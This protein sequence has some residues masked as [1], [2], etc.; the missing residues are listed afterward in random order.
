M[1]HFHQQGQGRPLVL[2]HGIGMSHK[3]WSPVFDLLAAQRKVIAFDVAGFGNSPILS[4]GI[5]PTTAN[6]A[7]QLGEELKRLGVTEPVDIVGNSM[8]GWMALEAARLGLA[9]SV[10]A[11]SP[12]GLWQQAPARAKYIFFGLR[13]LAGNFPQLTKKSLEFKI[14]RELFM[15]VPLSIGGRHIP[16]NIAFDLTMDFVNAQGF[17]ETFAHSTRFQDG[18]LIN[19][20]ITIAFGQ[21]DWLLNAKC[22]QKEELPSHVQWLEP[23]GWGHVPMWKDPHGVAQLILQRTSF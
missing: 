13:H 21:H 22:R 11:I 19:V 14:V 1:W 6:F 16:A 5:A 17:E 15:A 7:R 12:A 23:V 3:A 2:L 10:V 8:G 9:R 20:P 4:H 18:K